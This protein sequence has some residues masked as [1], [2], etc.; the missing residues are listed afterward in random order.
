MSLSCILTEIESL[1][2][3]TFIRCVNSMHGQKSIDRVN[4]VPRPLP[5]EAKTGQPVNLHYCILWIYVL[6][7]VFAMSA[8]NCHPFGHC[9]LSWPSL[10]R[11]LACID[12]SNLQYIYRIV[13]VHVTS[14]PGA[15]SWGKVPGYEANVHVEERN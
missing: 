9:I 6:T 15:L 12:E 10:S 14:C 2:D 1:D 13:R 8:M 5:H 4:L 11:T 3:V 7:S